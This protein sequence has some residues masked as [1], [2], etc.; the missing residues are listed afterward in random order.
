[1]VFN[2]TKTE[3]AIVMDGEKNKE[4][5]G[6]LPKNVVIEDFSGCI[7]IDAK[8][9]KALDQLERRQYVTS[10]ELDEEIIKWANK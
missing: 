10:E 6:G 8:I 2:H 9:E 4:I 5:L 7:V 1:M 3:K